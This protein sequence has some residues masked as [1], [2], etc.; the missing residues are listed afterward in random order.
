MPTEVY[1]SVAVKGL[2]VAVSF[3]WS[4]RGPLPGPR[5]SDHLDLSSTATYQ[6]SG[7]LVLSQFNSI[8]ILA[9]C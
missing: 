9:I 4:G 3:E 7:Y 8:S 2:Q 5:N 6:T 1:I